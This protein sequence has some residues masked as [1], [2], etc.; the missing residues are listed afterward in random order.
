MS[1]GPSIRWV[2]QLQDTQLPGELKHERQFG[3][4]LL[5]WRIQLIQNSVTLEP[6]GLELMRSL[7][8]AEMAVENK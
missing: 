1:S 3:G 7:Q 8:A 4:I 6:R 2:S 5:R